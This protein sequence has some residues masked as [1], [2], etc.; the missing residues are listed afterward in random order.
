[1]TNRGFKVM[2]P[3]TKQQSSQWKFPSES[4]PKKARQSQSNIKIML[5]FFFDY[6]GVMNHENAPRGQTRINK[7]FYV[8]VLKRLRD[9]E[10]RK[11]PYFG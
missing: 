6:E 5:I 3:K 8:E 2:T 1:M 10:R 4:R 11:L 9:T 7:E